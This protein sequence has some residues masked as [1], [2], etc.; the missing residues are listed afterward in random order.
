MKQIKNLEAAYIGI[1]KNQPEI[2]SSLLTSKVTKSRQKLVLT[3]FAKLNLHEYEKLRNLALLIYG[4]P[5]NIISNHTYGRK[6]L[7]Q[8]TNHIFQN[9]QMEMEVPVLAPMP[10]CVTVEYANAANAISVLHRAQKL[11]GLNVLK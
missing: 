7:T 1:K 10:M 3:S 11:S 9:V 4:S 8:T 6:K 2:Y 5:L